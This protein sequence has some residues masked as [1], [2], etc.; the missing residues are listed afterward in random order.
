MELFNECVVTVLLYLV[1]CFSPFVG[2]PEVRSLCGWAFIGIASLFAAMHVTL[3]FGNTC[4]SIRH[5]CRRKK[6]EAAKEAL[7]D[8]KAR[9]IAREQKRRQALAAMKD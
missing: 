5:C 6:L 1:L 4:C 7:L 3:L 2:D 9:K 8:A